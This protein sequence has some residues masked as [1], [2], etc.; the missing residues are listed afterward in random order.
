MGN[1]RL[2]AKVVVVVVFGLAVGGAIYLA[3][4]E[5]WQQ[6]S[7]RHAAQRP[8]TQTRLVQQEPG[9]AAVEI[10][11]GKDKRVYR[12]RQ[13][14]EQVGV[15]EVKPPPRQSWWDRLFRRK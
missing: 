14:G 11:R 5:R 15:E 2:V 10:Q 7:G 12:F 8:Q 4:P 1:R 13:V 6:H 3:H 9:V